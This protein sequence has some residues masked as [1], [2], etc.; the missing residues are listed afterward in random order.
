MQGIVNQNAPRPVEGMDF[1][2]AATRASHWI[3]LVGPF[4][5]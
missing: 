5:Q 3:T 1:V 4:E 2:G